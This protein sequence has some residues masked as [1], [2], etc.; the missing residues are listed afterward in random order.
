MRVEL[1]KFACDG[2]ETQLGAD[3]P[4]GVRMALFH[5]ASK[6]KAGRKPSP[7]PR[8]LSGPSPEVERAFDLTVDPETEAILERDALRQRT[9]TDRLVSHAVL[10]YLAELEF[11][12]AAPQE[13]PHPRREAPRSR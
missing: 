2:I 13:Q 6:L 1:S 3:I 8:F 5:Y 12:G 7:F 4:G 9:T 11:L 10:V